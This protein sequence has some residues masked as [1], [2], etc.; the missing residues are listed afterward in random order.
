MSMA[1]K[2]P[3]ITNEVKP[4]RRK[5]LSM[6]DAQLRNAV[7][8]AAAKFLTRP[9]TNQPIVLIGLMGVGKTA[10]GKRLAQVLKLR[11]IDSDQEIEKAAGMKVSEIFEKFG[12]E[13]FRDRERAVI[14]RLLN[15]RASRVIATGGGAFLNDETRKLI[16]DQSLAVWL[17]APIDVLVERTGRRD[18]RPLLQAGNPRDILSNLAKIREKFYRQASVHCNSGLGRLDRTV[19]SLLTRANRSIFG[20]NE[21]K[22][23]RRRWRPK[24][25]KPETEQK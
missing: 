1:Q 16:L 25:K 10:V 9:D 7:K 14:A 23:R 20:E 12:E 8:D 3:N 2:K 19:L 15:E 6:S 24:S 11:F 21:A 4:A 17:R 5:S 18:T 13:Y 22:Q